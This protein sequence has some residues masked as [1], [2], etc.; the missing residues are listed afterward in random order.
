MCTQ[1]KRDP[2]DERDPRRKRDLRQPMMGAAL[3]IHL[4][5][6]HMT[7][8]PERRVTPDKR[9]TAP[10]RLANGKCPVDSARITPEP[11][12]AGVWLGIADGVVAL[13]HSWHACTS[14]NA[15]CTSPRALCMWSHRYEHVVLDV[16]QVSF[17]RSHGRGLTV[18]RH[19]H[20][21]AQL[22]GA[23]AART[24]CLKT[25][26][27][28]ANQCESN[29]VARVARCHRSRSAMAR[30]R[31]CWCLHCGALIC[32]GNCGVLTKHRHDCNLSL[33][34]A[35]L[36]LVWT[37][38]VAAVMHRTRAAAAYPSVLEAGAVA[39]QARACCGGAARA[40]PCA[41]ACAR[42][43]GRAHHTRHVTCGK[44]AAAGQAFVHNWLPHARSAAM[45]PEAPTKPP[46]RA[47]RCTGHVGKTAASTCAAQAAAKTAGRC[48]PRAANVSGLR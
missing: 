8:G 12:E 2:C 21:D 22:P 42:C 18:D 15:P 6:A 33:Q 4:G 7:A 38:K 43:H 48:T 5:I 14:R 40:N 35:M 39:V 46:R 13:P 37:V 9:Q 20:Q 30:Q 17:V 31:K 11:V 44:T 10:G 34:R 41:C 26:N 24:P 27:S 23:M 29:D 3:N 25:R 16:R 1:R 45:R 47:C 36:Q 19:G 32:C 28:C